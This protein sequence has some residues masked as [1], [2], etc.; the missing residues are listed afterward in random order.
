MGVK[1]AAMAV[2]AAVAVALL[3][4]LRG[5]VAINRGANLAPEGSR[6]R[7]SAASRGGKGGQ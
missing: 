1:G 2:P 6:H 5:A 7:T 3:S 4:W